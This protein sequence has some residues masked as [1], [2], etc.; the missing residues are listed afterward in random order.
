M[1]ESFKKQVK[2]PEIFLTFVNVLCAAIGFFK[3]VYVVRL[4][5]AEWLGVLAIITGIVDM[6]ANFVD[7]RFADIAARLFYAVPADEARASK[8][9]SIVQAG[10]VLQG[11]LAIC[12]FLLATML[13]YFTASYFTDKSIHLFWILGIAGSQSLLYMTGLFAFVQRFCERYFSLGVLQLLTSAISAV[14]LCSILFFNPSL[15]GYAEGAILSAL[16]TLIISVGGALLLWQRSQGDALFGAMGKMCFA[17][18]FNNLRFI[19]WTNILGYAKLLHRA[20]DVLV[21]GW[22]FNDRET[23]L[24][25]LARQLTDSLYII[26]DALNKIYQP[27]FLAMLAEGRRTAFIAKARKISLATAVAT[28]LMVVGEVI[29]LPKFM[30]I[31]FSAEF[32]GSISSIVLL[33]IPFFFVVGLSLWVWPLL[34]HYGHI[35]PFT[36]HSIIAVCVGQYGIP[37]ALA[38]LLGHPR[39]EWFALGYL[40]FYVVLY[41]LTYLELIKKYSAYLPFGR[42]VSKALSHEI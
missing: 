38:G 21:V 35:G 15:D 30:L 2:R 32:I 14:L 3:G 28:L 26:Y 42:N 10:L 13:T 33:S 5:G 40:C 1:I 27:Q 34:V 37:L 4:L 29:V 8:R 18:Y 7:L 39:I 6:I 17:G 23:G 31:L 41:S 19:F 24:Y 16:A 25:K 20:A 11:G 22:F 36:F 12:L 9:R